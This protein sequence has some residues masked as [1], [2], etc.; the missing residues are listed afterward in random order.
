MQK[1]HSQVATVYFPIEIEKV[2]FQHRLAMLMYCRAY[3]Q[4]GYPS[5]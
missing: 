5:N 3:A 4:A 1:M 2:N